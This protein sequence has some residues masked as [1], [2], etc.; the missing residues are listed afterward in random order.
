MN[1]MCPHFI[2]SFPSGHASVAVYTFTF[3]VLYLHEVLAVLYA[4]KA[5]ITKKVCLKAL[6]PIYSNRFVQIRFTYRLIVTLVF[7]WAVF[8]CAS[9]V[10]DRWHHPTDVLAGVILGE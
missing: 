4:L 5:R 8:V 3:I 10:F 9:R 7:I 1:K 2:H 6:T